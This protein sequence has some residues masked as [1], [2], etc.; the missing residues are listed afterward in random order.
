MY[1]VYSC[2]LYTHV[3]RIFMYVVYSHTMYVWHVVSSLLLHIGM[4]HIRGYFISILEAYCKYEN[5]NF[6][7]NA[8]I[9]SVYFPYQRL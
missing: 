9:N 4:L 5:C 2:M 3:C 7:V 1:V 8:I 6:I